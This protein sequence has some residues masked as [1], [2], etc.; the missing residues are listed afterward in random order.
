MEFKF[1][2]EDE[3]FRKELLEFVGREL[4]SDWDGGGRPEEV[5]WDL[6]REMRRKMAGRGWLTMHWPEEY[7]GQK[8]S[9]IRSAIFNEEMSYTRTPGR[10]NFGVRML[11]STLMIHGTDEQKSIH[12]P[13]VARGEVQWCQ[14]YS[15]P[16]TGSDLASLDT[17]AVE[18]KEKILS[19]L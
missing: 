2:A 10:D 16:E 12:L 13:P 8:A 11:G 7:G 19:N 1:S 5:D 4:P 9:P 17:R 14:G 3:A 15:E 18:E 6:T